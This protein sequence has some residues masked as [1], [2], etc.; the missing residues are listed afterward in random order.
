MSTLRTKIEVIAMVLVLAAILG[1]GAWGVVYSLRNGG[2]TGILESID[3]VSRTRCENR[4]RGNEYCF[5][6]CMQ[7]GR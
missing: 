2:L 4:C 1:F 6:R 3:D 7:P 5:G